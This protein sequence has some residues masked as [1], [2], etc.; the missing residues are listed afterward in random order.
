MSSTYTIKFDAKGYQVFKDGELAHEAHGEVA[1][2]PRTQ[3]QRA[4]QWIRNQA[5]VVANA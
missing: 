5:E 2:D 3:E 1:C 4:Q